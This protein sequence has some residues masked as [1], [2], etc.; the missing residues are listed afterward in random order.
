[1][2]GNVFFQGTKSSKHERDP[3][4]RSGSDPALALVE[5]N[6]GFYLTIPWPQPWG[7]NGPLN[8]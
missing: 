4:L 1:M 8:R 2:G 3:I 6:D 7:A 5:K